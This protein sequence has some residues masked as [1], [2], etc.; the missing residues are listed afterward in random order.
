MVSNTGMD[1]PAPHDHRTDDRITELEIKASFLEEALEQLDQTV[2]RQQA[3]MERLIR[4]VTHLRQQAPE[5]GA[6]RNLRDELPPHY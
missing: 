3:Q 2:I 1:A 5:A 4:E 6:A